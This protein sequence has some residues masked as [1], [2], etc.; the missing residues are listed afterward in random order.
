MGELQH[1]GTI[2]RVSL[3]DDGLEDVPAKID[4]GADNSAI[5]ASNIHLQDGELIFNFFAPGSVFYREE[6]VVSTAFRTTTVRNSFGQQEFRYKIRLRIKVGQHTLTRWFTLADRSRNNYPILLGKNFLKSRFVVDVSQKHIVSTQNN[7]RVLILTAYPQETANFFEAVKQQNKLPVSYEFAQYSD[8]YFH[9]DGLST[10]VVNTVSG[11]DL[12]DYSFTYFKN[13]RE[14][15]LSTSAAEYLH[16]KGRSFADQEFLHYM[17]ASK[18]S[19]YMRLSCYGLSVPPTIAAATAHLAERYEELVKALG[20]PFVLKE[21]RSDKGKFNYLISQETDFK[22]VLGEAPAAHLYLAQKYVPNAGFYRLYITGKDVM[23][24]IWRR[25]AAHANP[26][27]AHLNKPRGSANAS[28]VALDE[29]PGE[30]QELALKA[31][32]RLNRQ[33]CG[34][35]LLQDKE[36]GIWYLL[37]ANNDPQIRSGSFVPAKAEMIAKYIDRELNQ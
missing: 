17:S 5:W 32:S 14:R 18:L 29:V 15:E 13:H 21:I 37:E 25:P 1:I 12:S 3:P 2:E 33:V 36:T 6:P 24:A 23:L 35:D 31:A 26:L 10:R 30:A 34:V 27:K 28:L 16:F 20:K 11:D 8:L 9:I 4:T 19:E 22:G 7:Q